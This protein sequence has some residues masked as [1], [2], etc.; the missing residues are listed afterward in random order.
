MAQGEQRAEGLFSPTDPTDIVHPVYLDVPMVVSFV[1]ALEGGVAYGDRRTT[2]S[3]AASGSERSVG[4]KAGLPGIGS[5]LRLEL[6]G[7]LKQRDETESQ[8][9][10]EVERQHTGASLFNLLRWKL[11]ED[12]RLVKHVS[13]P[14][15]LQDLKAGALVE[16]TGRVES[17]PLLQMYDA[18]AE[19]TSSVEHFTEVGLVSSL[20]GQGLDS[21]ADQWRENPE[22][23]PL[24]QAL[25]SQL[26][27]GRRTN[28]AGKGGPGKR[29][30]QS[31]PA[32]QTRSSVAA[33]E[34]VK[35]VSSLVKRLRDDARDDPV[36]DFALR[37]ASS[38]LRAVLTLSRKYLQ[39]GASLM[40]GG[41]FTVL[42]KV[43][44]V[45]GA[46][47]QIDLLRRSL[48]A[49]VPP[50]KVEAVYRFVT[51]KRALNLRL[52]ELVIRGPA[53][54]ILPIAVFT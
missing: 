42:G 54:Q 22:V 38:E 6:S 17:D 30:A 47:E 52:P 23:A 26:A 37:V 25:S 44:M 32:A 18:L 1:A 48:F 7:D 36:T 51:E 9:Q 27:D 34:M 2:K 45:L 21:I 31:A 8:E 13:V 39:D 3:A 28:Q 43:T 12:L 20:L 16:I 14:E 19:V 53:L 40:M 4:A 33:S 46:D 35:Q 41:E 24:V 11:R 50:D 5:L 49:Y 29:D 15:D 10:V